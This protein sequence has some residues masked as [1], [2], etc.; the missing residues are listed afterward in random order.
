MSRDL[1]SVPSTHIVE[2]ES[3]QVALDCDTHGHVIWTHAC[4]HTHRT[5]VKKKT[6]NPSLALDLKYEELLF[7][8]PITAFGYYIRLCS[9]FLIVWDP[10]SIHGRS[11]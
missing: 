6:K 3:R 2:G 4:A 7:M 10:E 1:G 5:N 9:Y 11:P 8:L